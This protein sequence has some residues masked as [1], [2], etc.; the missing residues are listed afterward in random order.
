MAPRTVEVLKSTRVGK[1]Y[2]ARFS[3]GQ[4]VHFGAKGIS[5]FTK[6][7][8]PERRKA[9]L[10]RHKAN[11]NWR[12]SSSAGFWSRHL[13]WEKPTLQGAAKA[14]RSKGLEVSLRL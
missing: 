2:Q 11:E 6:N 9:Y 10:A 1:K 13:L 5:D 7:K 4:T 12:D 14:L 3:D 8:D